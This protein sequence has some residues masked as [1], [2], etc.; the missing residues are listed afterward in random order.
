M[1][2]SLNML[3]LIIVK[4]I[5]L[6]MMFND[7]YNADNVNNDHRKDGNYKNVCYNI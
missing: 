3:N 6:L 7:D 4:I 2:M 5:F 1:M